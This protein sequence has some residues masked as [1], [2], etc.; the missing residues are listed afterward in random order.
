VET[1]VQLE[2][3]ARD[4]FPGTDV[5]LMAAAVA[6]FT[7]AAPHEAKIT[8][9]GRDELLVELKPTT[10]VLAALASERRAGQTVVGFAAEHGEGAAERARDKLVRKGVDAIVLNDVSRPGIGFD[11]PENEVLIVTRAGTHEV[12][13]ALKEEVA[14]AI[15]EVVEELH[16]EEVKTS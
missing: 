16:A 10:D 2:Q 5:L 7:P 1:A 15:I 4:E 6:D 3:A 14:R 8:K 12:P 9:T 11:S 13:K